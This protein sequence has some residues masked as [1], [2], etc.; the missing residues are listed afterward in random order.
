M[1]KVAYFWP[2]VGGWM[3]RLATPLWNHND[4]E[5]EPESD[6]WIVTFRQ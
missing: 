1:Y 3:G 5:L 2:S 6:D 4:N